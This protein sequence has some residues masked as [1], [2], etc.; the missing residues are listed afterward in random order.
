MP[1]KNERRLLNKLLADIG[2]GV[3]LIKKNETTFTIWWKFIGA[4]VMTVFIPIA[5]YKGSL[6]IPVKGEVITL[7]NKPVVF[8]F[9]LVAFALLALLSYWQGGYGLY[10]KYIAKQPCH[11]S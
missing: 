10:Q 2:G 8:Q 11:E 6:L 3:F 7:E 9:S 5:I 4:I 1:D